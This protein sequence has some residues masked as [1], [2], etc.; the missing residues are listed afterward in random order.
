[1]VSQA[2]VII[3]EKS[4]G[5][6]HI[7]VYHMKTVR[8]Q[9]SPNLSPSLLSSE[10]VSYHISFSLLNTDMFPSSIL[11]EEDHLV[12]HQS[13]PHEIKSDTAFLSGEGES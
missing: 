10:N 4:R 1:M 7:Q 5:S 11:P 3:K 6:P 2:P 8:L 12:K 9:K 13:R